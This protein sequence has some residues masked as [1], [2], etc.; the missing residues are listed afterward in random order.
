MIVNGITNFQ[1]HKLILSTIQC[2]FFSQSIRNAPPSLHCTYFYHC[3]FFQ[4]T[5]L[6]PC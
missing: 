3:R 4:T 1:K 6:Q 2:Q 5:E